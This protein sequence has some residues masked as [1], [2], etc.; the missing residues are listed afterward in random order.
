MGE[1]L[2]YLGLMGAS[3]IVGRKIE[4]LLD[5]GIPKK[6]DWN[7]FPLR[8]VVASF[9]NSMGGLFDDSL[10]GP[11]EK[12]SDK[13]RFERFVAAV[14]KLFNESIWGSIFAPTH[15]QL[16]VDEKERTI[17]TM[18][19]D[20][21]KCKKAMEAI[22]DV[23]DLCLKEKK[24]EYKQCLKYFRE[25]MVLLR[26]KDKFTNSDIFEFQQKADEFFQLWE[27]VEGLAGMTNYIHMV[28]SGHL[29]DYLCL[30]RNLFVFSNQGWENFNQLLKQVY[31]RRTGRGGGRHNSAKARLLPLAR[32]LQRRFVWMLVRNDFEAEIKSRI[33]KA[34]SDS[35]F[36]PPTT[37]N[38]EIGYDPV[39]ELLTAGGFQ[40]SE[41]I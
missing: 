24:D 18:C 34:H 6:R 37:P 30:H 7:M 21:E 40:L 22:D 39:P 13:R 11:L 17:T 12:P 25:A 41:P 26:Q 10:F 4:E 3:R 16:P 14:Q 20:N 2:D 33:E 29:A 15:W 23:I 32:W 35:N 1:L 36:Q 27:K 19:L 31:F 28:G 5:Q 38:I 9:L 8:K